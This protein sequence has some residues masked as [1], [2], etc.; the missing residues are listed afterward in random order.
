MTVPAIREAARA[1]ALPDLAATLTLAGR[2]AALAAAGDVIALSG[3]L[4]AGKTA[5]ARAF[6]N[7][8]S[9]ESVEVPSPTFTLLQTYP[10][11]RGTIWHFDFYRLE[12]AEEAYELGIEE[13]FADGISLI[14]WP[15]RVAA[16]LPADLLTVALCEAAAP[17]ARR[18]SLAGRG[19][20]SGRLARL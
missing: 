16:L 9:G 10:T 19:T 4:G 17:D 18:A 3:P 14:E 8:L 20:W 2:L 1:F 7:S 13:A 15:E 11:P 6:I 5:F 12:R